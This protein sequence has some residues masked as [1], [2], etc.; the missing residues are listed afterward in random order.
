M[1]A[2]TRPTVTDPASAT[3]PSTGPDPGAVPAP[4][5]AADDPDGRCA[6]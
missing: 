6:G 3:E 2:E 5:G 1:T 4:P